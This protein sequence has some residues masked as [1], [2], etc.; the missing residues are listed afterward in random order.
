[1]L[2][3]S[4]LHAT[5]QVDAGGLAYAETDVSDATCTQYSTAD[6]ERY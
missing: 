3:H 4:L 1:M 5:E 6:C 2:M